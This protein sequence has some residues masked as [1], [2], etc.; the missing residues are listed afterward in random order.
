[1]QPESEKTPMFGEVV[2]V[3]V[4]EMSE[5][6]VMAANVDTESVTA[7]KTIAMTAIFEIFLCP[8]FLPHFVVY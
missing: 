3:P 5:L 1:V 8:M 2:I 6:R 7:A 4:V